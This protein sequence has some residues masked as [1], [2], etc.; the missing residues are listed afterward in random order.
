MDTQGIK[1]NLLLE[2][3]KL[4]CPEGRETFNTNTFMEQPI[5]VLFCCAFLSF[6]FFFFFTIFLSQPMKDIP[7]NGS[8]LSHLGYLHSSPIISGTDL[9][10]SLSSW[11]TQFVKHKWHAEWKPLENHDK[12]VGYLRLTHVLSIFGY[13]IPYTDF[14]LS[15]RQVCIMFW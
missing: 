4:E 7:E 10:Y 8:D 1:P 11:W 6:S 9:R 2:E 5:Y 15:A 12:H 13:I 3:T 14:H